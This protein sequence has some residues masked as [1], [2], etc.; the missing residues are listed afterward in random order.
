M[1]IPTD[2]KELTP[3]QRESVNKLIEHL[4]EDEDVTNVYTTMAESDEDEEE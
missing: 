4:E 1:R 2:T 3:E